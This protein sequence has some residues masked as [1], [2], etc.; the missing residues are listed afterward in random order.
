MLASAIVAKSKGKA[1]VPV[2]SRVARIAVAFGAGING[3]TPPPT[4]PAQKGGQDSE[5]P[6]SPPIIVEVDFGLRTRKVA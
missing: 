2:P 4:V 3:K 6:R 1:N 5:A